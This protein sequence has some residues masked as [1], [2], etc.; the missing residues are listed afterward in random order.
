MTKS[1]SILAIIPCGDAKI[2]KKQ[3]GAG[4][5]PAYKAYTGSPFV[6]NRKFA[7]YCAHECGAEWYILS[8]KHG[9]IPPE[10]EIPGPYNVSFKEPHPEQIS[11]E[12]LYD[13]VHE[14]RLDRF[15]RIIVLGGEHYRDRAR[16]AFLGT[17]CKLE[18]PT[19]DCNMYTS[20]GRL[21]ELRAS[22]YPCIE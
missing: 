19:E 4:P 21:K 2:W 13:Q 9:F 16:A 14:M 8:A 10:Y 17:D 1:T 15:D 6:V 5:T 22:G 20:P 11:A 12:D 18:F 7:E 3:P